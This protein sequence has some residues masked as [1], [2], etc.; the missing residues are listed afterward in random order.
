MG[1]AGGSG[2]GV[3]NVKA[4]AEEKELVT[5][6]DTLKKASTTFN[7]MKEG[8]VPK[9]QVARMP[10]ISATFEAMVQASVITTADARAL[11]A[12]LQRHLE[13]AE[14]E[15]LLGAPAAAAYKS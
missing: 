11:T 9:L 5:L 13:E 1:T 2:K 8:S 15:R 3:A 7:K 12:F 4:T 14:D 6:V 10:N